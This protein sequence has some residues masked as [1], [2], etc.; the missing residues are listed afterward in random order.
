MQRGVVALPEALHVVHQPALYLAR[1]IRRRPVRARSSSGTLSCLSSARI[2]ASNAKLSNV[3]SSLMATSCLTKG[4]E[5]DHPREL[6]PIAWT[7]CAGLR[8]VSRG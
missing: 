3:L 8:I 7:V 4:T 6:A 5:L 1:I 2:A